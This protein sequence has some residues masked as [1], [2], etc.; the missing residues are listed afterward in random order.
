MNSYVV[1]ATLPAIGVTHNF[2]CSQDTVVDIF[3]CMDMSA[4]NY[5]PDATVDDGSCDFEIFGCMDMSAINYN[6][7]ATVDNG[8]CIFDIFGC[9]DPLA[10]NH[11]PD[12]TDDDGSCEYNHSEC[13]F[14]SRIFGNTGVNMTIF[15]TSGVVNNLP[16]SSDFP[17]LV[18]LSPSGLI[19]GSASLSSDNLVGGQQ[20]LAIWG[21]DTSTPNTDI[22][23]AGEEIFFQLVDGTLLYDVDISF[24]GPNSYTI[25][26]LPAIGVTHNFVCSQETVVDIFGCMDMSAIN[27]NPNATVDDGSCDF[28]QVSECPILDFTYT[29]TGSNMTLLFNTD[30]VESADIQIGQMIGVFANTEEDDQTPICYGSSEWTG[31]QFSIAVWADDLTTTEIDGFQTGDLKYWL[32][33]IKWNNS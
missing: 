24:A 12:A 11:N 26:Q 27:Y 28:E 23:L 29:N 6:P 15:L 22:A 25:N 17:Y 1:N 9:T 2:V 21:D 7:N 19:I 10:L 18:A 13:I 3:G 5:N 32:S 20:S 8:S 31:T 4:I 30:F 33:A 14:P 16:I